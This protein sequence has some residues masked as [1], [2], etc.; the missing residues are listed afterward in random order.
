MKLTFENIFFIY[1]IVYIITIMYNYYN[2]YKSVK[3]KIP[4]PLPTE[5]SISA[6]GIHVN[7]ATKKELMSVGLYVFIISIAW[8]FYGIFRTN[9]TLNF[10]A[11]LCF[12]LVFPIS[13]TRLVKNEMHQANLYIFYSVCEIVTCSSIIIHYFLHA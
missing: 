9:Y 7:E 8:V 4:Q 1:G 10:C 13:T 12:R 6:Q 2:A 11:L 3:N 5:M